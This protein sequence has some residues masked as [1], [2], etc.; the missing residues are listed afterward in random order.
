[1]TRYFFH[2]RR[3]ATLVPDPDGSLLPDLR[4]VVRHAQ[5]V[6][7]RARR[8]ADAA[9]QPLSRT[10]WID[11]RD[12]VGA[13]VLLYPV[14]LARSRPCRSRT[15]KGTPVMTVQSEERLLEPRPSDARGS[16]Q[17]DSG[18]RLPEGTGAQAASNPA[19]HRPTKTPTRVRRRTW[20]AWGKANR[21]GPARALGL[22]ERWKRLLPKACW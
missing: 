2:L 13:A 4:A 19:G 18:R 6:A 17:E 22:G 10:S 9:H 5:T 3:P 20:A 12:E 1:M 8:A 11:V 21:L 15:R 16:P 7:Q 14:R